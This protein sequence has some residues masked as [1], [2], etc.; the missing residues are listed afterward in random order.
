[1]KKEIDSTELYKD[2]WDA[3][4]MLPYCSFAECRNCGCHIHK[5]KVWQAIMKA[6]EKHGIKR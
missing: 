3:I 5:P 4:D 6:P 1:M 2:L